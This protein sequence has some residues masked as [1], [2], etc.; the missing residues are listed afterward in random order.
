MITLDSYQTEMA[1]ILDREIGNRKI[2]EAYLSGDGYVTFV[3]LTTEADKQ[4]LSPYTGNPVEETTFDAFFQEIFGDDILFE[5]PT[6][7][8][9]RIQFGIDTVKPLFD[10]AGLDWNREI[11]R[12]ICNSNM[13]LDCGGPT[14]GLYTAE[15]LEESG[16]IDQVESMAKYCKICDDISLSLQ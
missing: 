6:F 4:T 14:E 16:V 11:G 5:I 1:A 8:I 7:T 13:I 10:A 12:I 15:E 9:F 2:E 3:S